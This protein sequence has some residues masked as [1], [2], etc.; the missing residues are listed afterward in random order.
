MKELKCPLCGKNFIPAPQHIY[1]YEGEVFCSW[2]CYNH[3]SDRK[4][5]KIRKVKKVELYS[6]NG[7]L[8]KVFTSATAAAEK[9]GFD[10]KKIQNAC[11]EQSTY[12]GYLWRYKNDLP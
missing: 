10:L 8:L 5:G 12:M 1:R 11:R 7:Y 3:R 2:T 4:P 9:T 6:E